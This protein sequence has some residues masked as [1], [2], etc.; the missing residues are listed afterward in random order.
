MVAARAAHRAAL[1]AAVEH[2]A[3]AAALAVMEAETA[4][5]R[6]RLRAVRDRWIPRLQQALTQVKLSLEEQERS[7]AARLRRALRPRA[8]D[9]ADPGT[10][11]A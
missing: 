9:T 3:A 5:T 4:T 6:Y 2:A 1:A 7:D 11:G 8:Q 10:P